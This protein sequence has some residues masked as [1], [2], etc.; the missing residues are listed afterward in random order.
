MLTYVPPAQR[1]NERRQASSEARGGLGLPERSTRVLK[2]DSEFSVDLWKNEPRVLRS[3]GELFDTNEVL[4]IHEI[5]LR[6]QAEVGRGADELSS[7]GSPGLQ[8]GRCCAPLED[9]PPTE[10][11]IASPLQFP[12]CR[13]QRLRRAARLGLMEAYRLKNDVKYQDVGFASTYMRVSYNLIY[14]LAV[15]ASKADVLV[16]D[17]VL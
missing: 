11:S 10:Q 12:G 17:V 9:Q 5:Q 15:R 3:K 6:Q 14:V 13:H 16:F 8:S 4:K 1:K 7:P 2:P